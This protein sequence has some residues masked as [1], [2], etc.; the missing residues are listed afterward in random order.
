[1]RGSLPLAKGIIKKYQQDVGSLHSMPLAATI[2]LLLA[3]VLIISGVAVL[4][5]KD[6]AGWWPLLIGCVIVGA[7]STQPWPWRRGAVTETQRSGLQTIRGESNNN[8]IPKRQG[9]SHR[10]DIDIIES[11]MME[12]GQGPG[13]QVNGLRT[14]AL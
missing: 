9:K 10:G 11:R 8:N 1:V 13:V 5:S 7:L 4:F 6:T 2:T 3:L 14:I 12:F